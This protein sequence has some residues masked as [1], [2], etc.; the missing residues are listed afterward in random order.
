[1]I[2]AVVLAA[3]ATLF[4]VL[5]IVSGIRRGSGSQDDGGDMDLGTLAQGDAVLR[6]AHVDVA[7]TRERSRRR[8]LWKLFVWLAP[9]SAFFYY[10]LATANPIRV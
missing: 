5:A 7:R 9:I 1:M 10:R 4:A 6:G 8:R 2:L 3:A